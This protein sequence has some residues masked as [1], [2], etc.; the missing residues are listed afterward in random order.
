[1]KRIK[2]IIEYDGSRY[3]GFQAQQNAH[4][5]QEEIEQ[6]IYKL[7]R[8]K[9][10]IMAAGRTDAG[11][12]A[13][14]QVATFD[15]DSSIPGPKW[16]FALNSFLP[17]DIQVLKSEQVSPHFNPRFDAISKLYRYVIY[18]QKSGHVF[19]RNYSLY[20]DESLDIDAMKRACNVLQGTHNFS[21]FCASGSSVKTFERTITFCRLFEQGP[22]LIMEIE[23]NGFLYNMVR[24][25]MG[26]L[27]EVGRG[28]YP[29]Q[30]L[31][32]IIAAQNRSLAGPT[33]APQ[34]L[35]L[36]RVDYPQSSRDGS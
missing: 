16:Q 22:C 17:D 20:D 34:G 30:Y 5:I 32:D 12:H 35:Y 33:I 29:P 1:M 31:E 24:I 10:S 23:A 11:V 2:I 9:V 25:I 8:D 27:R 19:Y 6:S 26:T 7:T 15:T 13:L 14:G 18:R 21:S 36:V 3:H 28:K 4:T